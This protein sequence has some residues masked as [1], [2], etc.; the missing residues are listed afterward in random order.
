MDKMTMQRM[1][2]LNQLSQEEGE[3]IQRLRYSSNKMMVLAD[4]FICRDEN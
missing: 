3:C 2:V 1:K 4:L